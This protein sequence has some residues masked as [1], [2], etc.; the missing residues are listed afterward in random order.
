LVCIEHKICIRVDR[1]THSCLTTGVYLL[2]YFFLNLFSHFSWERF[3][4]L[5]IIHTNTC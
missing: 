3:L 2:M 5:T 4:Y 1:A